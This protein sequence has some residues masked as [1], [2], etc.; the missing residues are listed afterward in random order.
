[1]KILLVK[2]RPDAVQ[3]GLAPFFQTIVDSTEE[4]IEKPDPG[5]FRVALDRAGARAETTLHV[6]DL[7]HVDVV[8]ARSAGLKGALLDPLD[9]YPGADAERFSSL[10][11]LA[12]AVTNL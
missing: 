10:A 1:M 2:P 9:L 4:G 7:Y 12:D 5:I 11:A 3:F 6:G 8:G